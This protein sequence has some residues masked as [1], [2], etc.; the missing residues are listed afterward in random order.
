VFVKSKAW[1]AKV[2]LAALLTTMMVGETTAVAWNERSWDPGLV[3]VP[4]GRVRL[5]RV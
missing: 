1:L 4:S 2:G 3:T 5:K